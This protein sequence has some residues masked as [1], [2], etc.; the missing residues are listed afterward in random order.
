VVAL[1]DDGDAVE[2]GVELPV[3]AAVEAMAVC[4]LSGAAGDGSCAAEAGEGAGVAKAPDV[5][6]LGDDRGSEVRA[7]AVKVSER[8]V[9]LD[10]QLGDLAVEVGDARVEVR[11][12]S[13]ELAYA[14]C[15]GARG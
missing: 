11:D 2:R 6:G 9:V 14:A 15:G 5:S 4:R 8:V 3:A 10:E 1:L 13:G 12:V 7:G